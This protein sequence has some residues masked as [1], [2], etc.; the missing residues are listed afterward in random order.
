MC[1]L[2]DCQDKLCLYRERLRE[3]ER[4]R[5]STLYMCTTA[6]YMFP[7]PHGDGHDGNQDFTC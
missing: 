1:V 3:R 6:L 5:E 2:G 7:A 4:E